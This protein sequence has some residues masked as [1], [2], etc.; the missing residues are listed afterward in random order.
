[1]EWYGPLAPVLDPADVSRLGPPIDFLGLNYYYSHWVRADPDEPTLGLRIEPHAGAG[2]TDLGWLVH[3]EGLTESLLRIDREYG[4]IPIAI[5]ESGAVYEDVREPDGRSRDPRR[6]DY[7]RRYLA[8]TAEAIA[9]GVPVTAYFAWALLDNFEWASGL[10]TRFGLV[11]VDF[12][13]Q[14]RAIKASGA[15][16]RDV[17]AANGQPRA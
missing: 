16:Y 4:P 10:G 12:D 14:E 1:M 2:H 13:T 6:I 17:I 7:H 8:A 3:P 11:Y 15:W 5:T 9:A